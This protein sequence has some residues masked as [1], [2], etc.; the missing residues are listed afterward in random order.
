MEEKKQPREVKHPREC[1]ADYCL[2][3]CE[4]KEMRNSRRSVSECLLVSCPLWPYR[5]GKL[6]WENPEKDMS[7]TKRERRVKRLESARR[8]VDQAEK[9]L[10]YSE[11]DFKRVS[12]RVESYRKKVDE[13]KAY[14]KQLEAAFY[15][16]EDPDGIWR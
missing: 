7:K 5:T 10:K 4:K 14:V 3:K 16:T 8:K 2:L 11:S 15:V 13:A 9:W 6:K 12:Q 1:I